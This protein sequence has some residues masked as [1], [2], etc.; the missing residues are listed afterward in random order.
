MGL[1]VSVAQ[2]TPAVTLKMLSLKL[3][4]LEFAFPSY[5][6]HRLCRSTNREFVKCTKLL[7]SLCATHISG[8]IKVPFGNNNSHPIRVVGH[9]VKTIRSRT[10]RR[11]QR[12]SM[13][14]Y[15]RLDMMYSFV[16]AKNSDYILQPPSFQALADI[17]APLT[18]ALN[19]LLRIVL[20]PTKY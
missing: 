6:Y 19:R 17:V 12:G 13:A 2:E 3:I 20:R 16:K 4:D 5:H 8:L 18:Y 10:G 11:F 7:I 14:D 9:F 1:I 15:S